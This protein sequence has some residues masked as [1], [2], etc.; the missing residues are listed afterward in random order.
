MTTAKRSMNDVLRGGY[1]SMWAEAC[2][3]NSLVSPSVALG[4]GLVEYSSGW[5]LHCFGVF[6][7]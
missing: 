7:P 4:C 3:G 2:L 1:S 5:L 6:A